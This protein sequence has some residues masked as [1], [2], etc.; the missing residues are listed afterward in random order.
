MFHEHFMHRREI[1]MHVWKIDNSYEI[2]EHLSYFKF[3]NKVG[4]NQG[5]YNEIEN[6]ITTEIIAD[7]VFISTYFVL[8][9]Q[10]KKIFDVT[11][12]YFDMQGKFRQTKVVMVENG[13]KIKEIQ[14]CLPRLEDSFF[15]NA[16]LLF[17]DK[18]ILIKM[19][20]MAMED[21][22]FLI[23]FKELQKQNNV[24]KY[25]RINCFKV[26]NQTYKYHEYYDLT[27]SNKHGYYLTNSCIGRAVIVNDDFD[28][29][30]KKINFKF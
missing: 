21:E 12:E 16:K 15:T 24:L 2:N 9:V 6:V 19:K 7:A 8:L 30:I 10:E 5:R 23:S 4:L 26:K 27:C 29:L 20:G 14:L 17:N 28:I 18:T 25:K 3:K 11:W 13:N 1:E 22:V